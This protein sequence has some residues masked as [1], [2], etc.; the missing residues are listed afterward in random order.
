MACGRR[1]VKVDPA[2]A[3]ARRCAPPPGGRGYGFA[4]DFLPLCRFVAFRHRPM[5]P[6]RVRAGTDPSR[7]HYRVTSWHEKATVLTY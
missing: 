6:R 4:R 5:L 2:L 1:P 3:S 7:G